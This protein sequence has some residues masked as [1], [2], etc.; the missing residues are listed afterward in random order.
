MAWI[1][2][3]AGDYVA[4]TQ[5]LTLLEH[6]AYICLLNQVFCTRNSIPPREDHA[7]RVC[8][9]STEEEKQAVRNVLAYKFQLNED[10]WVHDRAISEVLN[11]VESN[12][13]RRESGKAGGKASV[14]SRIKQCSSNTQAIV[15]ESESESESEEDKEQILLS[16]DEPPVSV[17]NLDLGGVWDYFLEMTERNPN[18]NTFTKTRQKQL[19]RRFNERIKA[20]DGNT[21]KAKADIR[22]A[23]D[24]LANSDFHMARGEHKG[25][26]KYNEWERIFFSQV[27]FEKWLPEGEEE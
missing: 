5:G 23:I 21:A 3:Y 14:Q 8:R 19:A 10:G 13:K 18:K 2:W 22:A 17:P 24:S 16:E 7:F 1:R 9:A 25:Q 6:G 27:K 12:E 20:N 26:K 15:D 11:A 4:A